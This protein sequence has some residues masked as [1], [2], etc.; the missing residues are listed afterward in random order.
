MCLNLSPSYTLSLPLS[1]LPLSLKPAPFPLLSLMYEKNRGSHILLTF[2]LVILA[3]FLL[4]LLDEE[5]Y[6]DN[7]FLI[8]FTLTYTPKFQPPLIKIVC[9]WLFCHEI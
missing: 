2:V 9:I 7:F 1:L 3:I 5:P 8:D 6:T 4:D